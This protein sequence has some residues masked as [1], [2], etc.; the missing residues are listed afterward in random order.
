MVLEGTW[1]EILAHEA[2]LRGRRLRVTVLPDTEEP[3]NA[4]NGSDLLQYLISIGFVGEWA[5]RT[6]IPESPEY[7]RLLRKQIEERTE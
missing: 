5:G 6:D 3:V 4:L 1:E 7:V 2:E